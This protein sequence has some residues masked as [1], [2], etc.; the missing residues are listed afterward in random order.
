MS[1]L[2]YA[3]SSSVGRGYG[4]IALRLVTIS[5]VLYWHQ[6]RC[7]PHLSFEELSTM[8]EVKLLRASELADGSTRVI[9]SRT[10]VRQVLVARI[11]DRF[12][13]TDAK[14]FHMGGSLDK[15]ELMD[16]EDSPNGDPCIVCPHHRYC[17]SLVQGAAT[18]PTGSS[19]TAAQ[20]RVHP[21]WINEE[22]FVMASIRSPEDGSSLPSD[23]YNFLQAAEPSIPGR[24]PFRARKS[25]ATAAVRK[26][27]QNRAPDC[28]NVEIQNNGLAST[29]P[30][31]PQLRQ[32]TL[33]AY[34]RSSSSREVP[35]DT[36]MEEL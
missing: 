3:S 33:D 6:V 36:P 14:C 29:S 18:C 35:E 24:L 16:I 34:L 28:I 32:G 2:A 25:C 9:S 22:G 12:Y 17:I 26:A 5:N 4:K 20:Q 31:S 30:R 15:G 11:G 27:Q 23:K 8:P 21:T 19:S 1:Y 7:V 13:T 10:N